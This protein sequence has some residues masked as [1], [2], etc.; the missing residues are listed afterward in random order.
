MKQWSSI[1]SGELPGHR[2]G[3]AGYVPAITKFD[4]D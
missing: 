1:S 4:K 3:G 2:T